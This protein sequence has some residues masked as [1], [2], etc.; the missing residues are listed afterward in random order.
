M[1]L[2]AMCLCVAVLAAAGTTARAADGSCDRNCLVMMADDYLAALAKHDPAGVPLAASYKFTENTGHI[3]AGE[4]LWV[5]ASNVSTTF[6]IHV[7]DPVSG[8]VGVF[9]VLKEFNKPAMFVL[10]LK[11]AGGK[12]TEIEHIV[13]RQVGGSSGTPGHMNLATS[14]PQF[15]QTVPPEERA[16][17]EEMVRIASSYFDAIEQTRGKAAPF[18][19]DCVRRENGAQ[20][21]SWEEPDPLADAATNAITSL[22]CAA[23][24]DSGELSYITRIQPRRLIVVDEEKGIVLGF[25]MFV[26]DAKVRSVKI[27]GVPGIQSHAKEF[28][29]FTLLAGEMFKIRGGKIHEVEAFGTAMPNGIPTGWE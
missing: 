29:P 25:P 2:R 12:I 4:G 22:G 16:P 5:G 13:V 15:A 21:T 1:R 26:H 20:T 19:D 6:R 7:A 17:R 9:T 8:Q 24:I 3:Q 27:V 10:R 18:A 14:R 11:V 28:A 23:Q